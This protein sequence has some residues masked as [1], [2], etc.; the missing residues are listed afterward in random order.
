MKEKSNTIYNDAKLW[1]IGFFSLNNTAT[2]LALFIMG[3]YS[4]YTQNVL[5]LAAAIIGI[6]ATSTR[7]FDA[8][9][10]PIIGFM[11]DKTDTKFGKLRPYMLIGNIIIWIC[12]YIIFTTP[13]DWSIGRKYLHTSFFYFVYIIGYTCQTVVTKAGQAVLTNNP[14]KRPYFSGFDGV[15]TQMAAALVPLLITS[16][17]ADKYSVGK[18]APELN[19]G[20]GMGMLNPDMW[21][22]AVIIV[23]LVSIVLTIL[24]IIGISEKDKSENFG[25]AS[26]VTNV[27]FSDYADIIKNNRAL[28]MLIVSAATDKLGLLLMNG[29]MTYVFANLILN[30]K[31]QGI[32][33]SYLMIPI[34][35]MSFA[36]VGIASRFGL[37]KAFLGSTWGSMILLAIMFIIRPNPEEPM[38]FIVLMIVQKC[39]ASIANS[40]VIPMIADCT[41]YEEYRSKNFVPGMIGTLFSFVD[42][43]VSSLQGLILGFAL[44]LAGVGHIVIEPNK[45]VNS[46]FNLAIMICFC[47]VP[48]LGH[49]ASIIA[50]K[51]YHLDAEEMKKIQIELEKRKAEA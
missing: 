36:G 47:I 45:P 48:I 5:G 31:L 15:F 18:F 46:T 7:L 12:M 13:Q 19:N 3:Q 35:I 25:S 44:T 40:A 49:L 43:V 14:K 16:I 4:Y 6:I 2:N 9:T 1:Q 10:D 30:V 50:M 26:I 28:Q 34:I 51:Y 37:K 29:T 11:V 20:K 24:A 8:I 42:K 39:I 22:E 27:K 23:G 33:S 17:L 32:Y 38:I 21:K 41:N